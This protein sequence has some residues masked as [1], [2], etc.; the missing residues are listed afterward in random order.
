MNDE[1]R[2]L[3]HKLTQQMIIAERTL[4]NTHFRGIKKS[5][6][7]KYS[8]KAHF[9]YELLQ[10]ADDARAKCARFILLPDRLIFAHNGT[11]LFTVTDVDTEE[12][13]S[14]NHRLGHV[15]SITSIGLSTKTGD[16]STIG[17]FG[18]GFKAVFQYT[19]TPRIYSPG[20]SFKI[21]KM[22]IPYEL[23]EDHP[24][25]KENETLFDLEFDNVNNPAP[26]AY[27]NIFEKLHAL[28]FPTLF[29]RYLREVTITVGD[30]TLVYKKDVKEMHRYI[31]PEDE[32]FT[33]TIA[34]RVDYLEQAVDKKKTTG[35][36]L[37]SRRV[38]TK[39]GRHMIYV[40]YGVNDDGHLCKILK[41]V[42]CF[43]PTTVDSHLNFII[44]APFLLTD[45]REGIIAGEPH[46]EEMIECLADLATDALELLRD[47]G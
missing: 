27:K 17:K 25:R 12:E 28:S 40:G 34:R 38:L 3:L 5:V 35:L 13:D 20:F 14:K 6:V 39:T 21:E 26:Q 45:S 37:F 16:H 7:D 42:F 22:V 9:V 36:W 29:L 30:E 44:H 15:N 23:P 31:A 24:D 1:Q 43:F 47:I 32:K 41:P 11:K 2:R 33:V 8:E 18:M 10:N 4:S 19:T 46:N